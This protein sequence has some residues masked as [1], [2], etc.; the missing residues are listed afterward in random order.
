MTNVLRRIENGGAIDLSHHD[1]QK[2]MKRSQRAKIKQARGGVG[3]DAAWHGE[4]QPHVEGDVSSSPAPGP[5]PTR[6]T[7]PSEDFDPADL[8]GILAR[9]RRGKANAGKAARS[10]TSNPPSAMHGQG[11][12]WPVAG[13][14]RTVS[15]EEALDTLSQPRNSADRVVAKQHLRARQVEAQGLAERARASRV[16]A[17][18][19]HPPSQLSAHA[20]AHSNDP[21]SRSP[22]RPS[23]RSL[24]AQRH[25]ATQ[26]P[27]PQAQMP[28]AHQDSHADSVPHLRTTS[29]PGVLASPTGSRGRTIQGHGMSIRRARQARKMRPR[30][31]SSAIMATRLAPLQGSQSALVSDFTTQQAFNKAATGIQALWRAV[32]VRWYDQDL[33]LWRLAATLIQ[34][35]WRRFLEDRQFDE[36]YMLPDDPGALANTDFYKTVPPPGACPDLTAWAEWLSHIES[37]SSHAA[38]DPGELECRES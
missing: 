29:A 31:S 18:V 23:S 20:H 6:A 30:S 38:A 1:I 5:L 21:Q 27:R 13:S 26:S 12:A 24:D 9:K 15:P 35:Q 33:A 22:S 17:E 16:A 19:L 8:R 10:A 4:A 34:R 7:Q 3:G 36:V 37:F 2:R 32:L 28:T 25:G 14:D 11:R